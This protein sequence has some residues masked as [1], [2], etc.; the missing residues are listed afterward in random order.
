ML[1][2]FTSEFLLLRLLTSSLVL[3]SFKEVQSQP[4]KD[5]PVIDITPP[6]LLVP[7]DSIVETSGP[8]G[9]TVMYRVNASDIVDGTL[10]AICNPISNSTFSLG[11][12]KVTCRAVDKSG[13]VTTQSFTIRVEDN[14]PPETIIASASAGI[15]GNIELNTSTLSDR[16]KLKLLATDNVGIDHFECKLDGNRWKIFEKDKHECIFDN[17]SS[18]S[19][20]VLV[21]S[22]DPSENIDNSPVRFRWSV[23]TIQDSVSSIIN[24][25]KKPLL[26][27]HFC[28][29]DD[30]LT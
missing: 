17:L 1:L 15:V 3:F 27:L 16:I 22:V 19:H 24:E 8:Y 9:R 30:Q 26:V 29:K 25:V 13:N 23:P 20:T 10:N 4:K 18:G 5:A 2:R 12:T 21:R 6:Q 28:L 7:H 11:E 14:T